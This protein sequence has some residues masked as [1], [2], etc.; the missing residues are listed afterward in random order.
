MSWQPLQTPRE[1]VSLLALNAWNCS[2]TFV[3]GED[4]GC[5]WGGD[6]E[7]KGGA[8]RVFTLGAALTPKLGK[9]AVNR[10][11]TLFGKARTIRTRM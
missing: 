4:K 6:R 3:G 1:N 10:I 8:F 11:R 7:G 5:G 2:H 9:E